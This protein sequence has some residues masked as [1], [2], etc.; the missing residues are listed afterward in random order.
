[1][2]EHKNPAR[3]ILWMSLLAALM[4]GC[5]ETYY[6]A[7][8]DQPVFF[9]YRYLNN[10]WGV[11]D[12]GWL[13]DSEGKQRGFDFPEAYRRPDSTGHL[14]LEDLNYNLGQTDTLLQVISRKK[15][16]KY[17]RLIGGAALGLLSEKEARGADMGSA[18]LS[19]YAYDPKTGTYQYVL[20]ATAGDWE[21]SNQSAEA[22][23]LVDWLE[24]LDGLMYFD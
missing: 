2:P 10:A 23:K 8:A 19:C 24:D 4:C 18:T 13:I 5:E 22:E 15:F 17:T 16:E 21:Q 6:Y 12:H 20:L 14:S 7:P 9:E 3:L 11:A 1:M